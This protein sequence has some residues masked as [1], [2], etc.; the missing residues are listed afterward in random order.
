MSE[1]LTQNFANFHATIVSEAEVGSLQRILTHFG[2]RSTVVS[3]APDI[4]QSV[5][6][7]LRPE[8]DLLIIDSDT[9]A[10]TDLAARPDGLLEWTS[11]SQEIARGGAPGGISLKP[12]AG[13]QF[14][15][16]D[17][18]LSRA[19]RCGEHGSGPRVGQRRSARR[20]EG[21]F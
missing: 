1:R 19:R 2:V 5:I 16:R 6:A 11:V 8:Q 18:L 3:G 14:W 17:T 12:T 4:V 15:V 7:L 13:S 20:C 10:A 9:E 21:I